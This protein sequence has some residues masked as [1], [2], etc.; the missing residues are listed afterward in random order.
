MCDIL[1][2]QPSSGANIISLFHNNVHITCNQNW[3]SPFRVISAVV[4]RRHFRHRRP[5]FERRKAL[6]CVHWCKLKPIPTKSFMAFDANDGN[7]YS[8]KYINNKF[9]LFPTVMI[10]DHDENVHWTASTIKYVFPFISLDVIYNVVEKK[11]N[12]FLVTHLFCVFYF[13]FSLVTR[14]IMFMQTKT[15]KSS[16]YDL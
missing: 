5:R 11:T 9:W 16:F 3:R 15:Q 13:L 7:A 14:C 12:R 4:C 10:N 8:L 1:A 2:R 6:M